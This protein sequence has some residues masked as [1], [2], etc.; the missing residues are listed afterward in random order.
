MRK[1][2][3]GNRGVFLRWVKTYG[4]TILVMICAAC[5]LRCSVN[6][7]RQTRLQQGIAGEVLRFHILANSDSGQDQRIKLLV[8]DRVLAWIE[9]EM[10]G[11]K[12]AGA[13]MEPEAGEGTFSS[14]ESMETRPDFLEFLSAHL[15]ELEAVA[16]A[17]LEEE[18]V[19]YRS[20]ASVRRCYFPVRTYGDCTF[21][22][23]WYEALRV[24]LGDAKGHNWWCVLYPRLCFT[25]S[26]HAVVGEDQTRKLEEVLT[27]EEYETLLRQPRKWKIS[28]RWF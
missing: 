2:E 28:F 16:D 25:D 4:M 24:C 12:K 26:L 6:L 27:V 1:K 23:G 8:R 21:P 13:K 9:E 14:E 15:S 17:A 10:E 18:G 11:E 20:S 7:A 22:A 3:S 5:I 19:R